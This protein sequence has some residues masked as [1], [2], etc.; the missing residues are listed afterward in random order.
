M[1]DLE[2]S[3]S[4]FMLIYLLLVLVLLVMKKLRMGQTKLLIT[5]S[6]KMTVQLVIAGLLL[7]YIFKAEHP[8][9][10]VLYLGVMLGFTVHRVLS[11]S[12]WMNFKFKAI[13]AASILISGILVLTYFIVAVAEQNLLNPQYVIPI[14]GMVVGN[15]MNAMTLALKAFRDGLDG[16]QS[17]INALLC[18][19]APAKN[20]L[21]PFAR[22]ALETA[23][24]PSLNSMLGMGIV[25]LPGMMTGQILAGAVPFT[26]ILY[27]IAIMISICAANVLACFLTLYFGCQT[28]YDRQTQIISIMAEGQEGP[29]RS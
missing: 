24:L 1:D 18:A 6:I 14:G 20:I 25:H 11:R 3:L 12:P 21:L 4:R 16:R 15:I 13:A 23:I 17:Q 26:A 19:G 22:Q 9:F 7:E 29:H 2:I 28:M 8:A 10:T 27:Q 5:A